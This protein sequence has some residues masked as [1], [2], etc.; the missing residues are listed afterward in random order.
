[1]GRVGGRTSD[2]GGQGGG[3]GNRANGGVDEVPDFS[4]VIVHHLQGLLPTIVAQ[5]GDNISNQGINGSRNNNATD[6]NIQEDDRNVNLGNDRNV[7]RNGSLKRTY[8][9]RVDG[10][11]SSKE[12]N[13]KGDNKR[14]RTG[15]VFAT[16]T[17]PVRKEYTGSTP[18]CTNCNFHHNPAMPCRTCTNCNRLGHFSRDYM[19]GP[20]MVN[21]LNGKNPTTAREACYECGGTDHNKSACPRNN[22]NLARG[23]EFMMGP[24]EARQDLNILTGTFFL[25]NHYATV[26]F[27]FDAN[28]SFVSTTSMPMLDIEPSSLGIDWLSRHRAEIVC[29]ERVVQIPLPRGEMLRVY[30][31][32]L[33]EKVFL[34]DLLGLPPSREVKFCIDLIL[35]ATPVVKSPYHLAPTEMEELLNRLK[36]LMDKGNGYRQKDKIKAK[37]NKTE[38]EMESVKKSKVKSQQKVNPVKVKDVAETKEEHEMHL[39]LILDL[40]KKEKHP[41]K[42]EVVKNWEAPKSP[43]EK[44]KKCVWGDEKDVAFQTL[45]DK[46]CNTHVPALPDGLEDFVVYYEASCQGLGCVLMQ[47]GKVIAYAS[48]Q[49]KIH[50]K[51]YT[52]QDLELGAVVVALKIWRHYLY[53]TKSVIYIDH[54]S[55]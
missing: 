32:L 36:E 11:E 28:Y 31:E 44:H 12:G 47:K 46:L 29:H 5:V 2:Q 41:N 20:R 38:H 1:M 13:V 26:L 3:R 52:T 4:T 48:R 34:D 21:L 8:E 22:D 45:K 18:K 9:R 33:E 30:G 14:A 49:L 17:N 23:R 55:L 7:V 19:E 42:V 27:D 54:K 16:I 35:G 10:G 50:E 6:N 24:E 25:N 51:N 37:L 43:T 53:G 40:L 39:G 15:K